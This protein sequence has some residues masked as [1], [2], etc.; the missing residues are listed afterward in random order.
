MDR[1]FTGRIKKMNRKIIS[2]SGT[3]SVGK[4]TVFDELKET[5]GFVHYNAFGETTR[6]IKKLGIEI[7]ESGAAA[8]QTLIAGMHLWN[9]ER[10][11]NLLLDRSMIDCLAYTQLLYIDSNE[12]PILYSTLNYV[13]TL[14]ARTIKDIDYFIYFPIEFD[15]V[16]DGERTDSEDW[17]HRADQ[18]FQ[19]IFTKYRLDHL[20]VSGT[21]EERIKQI[22]LYTG[23]RI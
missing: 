15:L 4:T 1:V 2:L 5:W 22:K 21:V 20:R 13:E 11:G 19:G 12:D 14:F 8:S 6:T 7:N 17:R 16:K 18:I 3:S 23:E 9:L 10:E